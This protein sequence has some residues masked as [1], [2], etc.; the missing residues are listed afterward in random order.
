VRKCA[1]LEISHSEESE[2][3][4]MKKQICNFDA[5]LG[6]LYA[7]SLKRVEARRRMVSGSEMQTSRKNIAMTRVHV[8]QKV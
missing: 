4:A 2:H 5:V 7:M 8:D 6:M 1:E 3:Q